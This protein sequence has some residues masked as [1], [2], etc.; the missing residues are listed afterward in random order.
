ME[1]NEEVEKS[2]EEILSSNILDNSNKIKESILLLEEYFFND[3]FDKAIQG[4][5]IVKKFISDIVNDSYLIKTGHRKL[6]FSFKDKEDVKNN[7]NDFKVLKSIKSFYLEKNKSLDD[8]KLEELDNI[9]NIYYQT[10]AE[11]LLNLKDLLDEDEILLNLSSKVLNKVNNSKP[12][13]D[14]GGIQSWFFEEE[15]INTI[16]LCNKSIIKASCLHILSCVCELDLLKTAIKQLNKCEKF[17]EFSIL[18]FL[19]TIQVNLPMMISNRE[20]IAFGFGSIDKSTKNLLIPF[21]SINPK[22]KKYCGVEVP[23]IDSNYK[24]IYI[25][26]GFLNIKIIDDNTCEITQCVNVNPKVS[27]VPYFIINKVLKEMSYYITSDLI[28]HVET[29]MKEDVYEKRRKSNPTLYNRILK[30]LERLK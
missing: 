6:S 21:K 17:G 14:S 27:L 11:R 25:E 10:Y 30:E 19:M 5:I 2:L 9:V 12:E 28:K 4:H 7:D 29:T 22:I 3:D 8:I 18:R 23:A 16:T 13:R 15:G 24:R 26:F 1:K 20:I